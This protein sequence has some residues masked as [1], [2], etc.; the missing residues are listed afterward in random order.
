MDGLYR[1]SEGVNDIGIAI[2][3]CRFDI[4]DM[5]SVL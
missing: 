5:G 2:R 3:A 1:R 4:L